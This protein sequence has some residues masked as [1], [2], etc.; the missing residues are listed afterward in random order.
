MA[1]FLGGYHYRWVWG[2][3]FV[4]VMFA[5]WGYCS[6]ASVQCVQVGQANLNSLNQEG[7][8][9][10]SGPH[11]I[12]GGYGISYLNDTRRHGYWTIGTKKFDTTHVFL[13][14]LLRNEWF[15]ESVQDCPYLMP[16]DGGF[17]K[18]FFDPCPNDSLVTIKTYAVKQDGK[19]MKG[20]LHFEVELTDMTDKILGVYV[21]IRDE[22]FNA[23]GEFVQDP[24]EQCSPSKPYLATPSPYQVLPCS[25]VGRREA[26]V[27]LIDFHELY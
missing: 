21:Q 3:L 16:P 5:K 8:G 12:P 27:N 17:V 25:A 13:D 11:G 4:L 19:V 14:N 7:T 10:I 22:V 23:I 1:D 18:I 26:E 15:D 20:W 24:E 9:D 6:H 2:F